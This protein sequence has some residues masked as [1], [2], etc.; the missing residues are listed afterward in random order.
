MGRELVE[1]TDITVV[2][3]NLQRL[4]LGRPGMKAVAIFLRENNAWACAYCSRKDEQQKWSDWLQSKKNITPR[5][6]R[7]HVIDSPDFANGEKSIYWPVWLERQLLAA[8]IL[9]CDA[10]YA[11]R[12]CAEGEIFILQIALGLRRTKLFAEVQE[13]SRNDGL[14]GLYLRRYFLER[15]FSEIQRAKRYSMGFSLMMLDIDL[16]K[17]V[18]D[19]FGHLAGDGVLKAIAAVLKERVR[20]GDL[21]CRYGGEEFMILTP[22]PNPVDSINAAEAMRKAVEVATF[23]SGAQAIRITVSIGIAHYPKD[24]ATP[25]DILSSV[26]KALYYSKAHGR[27]LV[28]NFRNIK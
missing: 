28:T 7:F 6:H 26:D 4:L 11:E 23:T 22:L 8:I 19:T 21:I 5:E 16:F 2:I 3:D 1:Y 10:G 13:R 24:G 20:P 12:Y 18:N 14:T 17:R 9:T 27:N 15:L 25:E